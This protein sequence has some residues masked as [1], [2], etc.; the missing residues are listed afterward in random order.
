MGGG[1]EL[2]ET[3]MHGE[4][5][6]PIRERDLVDPL[7]HEAGPLLHHTLQDDRRFEGGQPGLAGPGVEIISLRH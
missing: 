6:A 5:H 1:R 3:S 4:E 2:G 7:T